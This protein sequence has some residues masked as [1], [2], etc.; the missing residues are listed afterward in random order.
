MS[1]FVA[2]ALAVLG[3]GAWLWLRD[4]SLVS[5]TRVA[6]S[7]VDGLQAG[8]ITSALRAAARNMTTLDVRT[9]QLR[10]AVSP[11]PVVKDLE[12]S[13]QFPHGMRI[14][15]IEQRPVGAVVAAGRTI[16]VAGD[17]TLLHDVPAAALPTIPLGVPPG[18][19][20]LTDPGARDAAALLAAAP[21]ALLGRLIQV[22]TVAPHGLV[23]QLRNGPSIYFGAANRLRA[24]WMAASE[25]L[26]D[27]GS[28]GAVYID[29]TVPER[30]A[31][32]AASSASSTGGSSAGVSAAAGTSSTTG[33]PTSTQSGG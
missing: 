13:T 12:V 5:V 9:D 16:A 1:L 27:S 30:P 7:G 6:V 28:A 17:G 15:V 26:A 29:V 2:L 14:H 24:K 21:T 11:Y 10:M 32:G 31:A 33:E 20:R 19:S 22:T 25:V 18:G 3:G 23:A 4:S 8:Q